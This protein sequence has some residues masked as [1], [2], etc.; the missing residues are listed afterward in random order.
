[1]EHSFKDLEERI[2]IKNNL[3]SPSFLV[4]GYGET[5]GA[6]LED[7][8]YNM[9]VFVEDLNKVS[10]KEKVEYL[11]SLGFDNINILH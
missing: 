6:A 8:R 4:S 3:I 10:L 1:M 9:N 11:Q 5:E 7:F 2:G